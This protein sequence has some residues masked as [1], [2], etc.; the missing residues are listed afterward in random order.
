MKS[1]TTLALLLR[2]AFSTLHTLIANH[3]WTHTG[4]RAVMPNREIRFKFR[5]IFL[6]FRKILRDKGRVTDIG[7][8][9]WRWATLG[10]SSTELLP[11]SR[12]NNLVSGCRYRWQQLWFPVIGNQKGLY[13]R[14]ALEYILVATPLHLLNYCPKIARK[15]LLLSN[16]SP[17]VH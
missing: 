4:Y 14:C 13:L 15:K 8:P 9:S 7:H 17:F 11:V 10:N 6:K 2:V 5:D 1:T 16:I 12:S 3:L